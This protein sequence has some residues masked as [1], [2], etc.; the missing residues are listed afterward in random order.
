M[1]EW[2][3]VTEQTGFSPLTSGGNSHSETT[4]TRCG[5][6][7]SSCCSCLVCFPPQYVWYACHGMF[8]TSLWHSNIY[9]ESYGDKK[10]E[11][12]SWMVVRELLMWK[13]KKKKR[14][15]CKIHIFA[16]VYI[17]CFRKCWCSQVDLSVMDCVVF[18]SFVSYISIKVFRFSMQKYR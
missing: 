12:V 11:I 2:P 13:A 17:Y 1:K 10:Y 18:F 7:L 8:S 4:L 14:N 15:S 3:L 6:Q 16:D 5:Q 9:Q